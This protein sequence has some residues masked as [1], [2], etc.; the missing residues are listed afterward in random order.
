MCGRYVLRT[1]ADEVARL[2]GAVLDAS[3]APR[4]NI[5]PS[6]PVPVVRALDDGR[7]LSL[8]RWGLIPRWAKDPAIG[9]RLINA[10]S[11]TAAEK[12]SFR[13]AFARRRCLVPADAFYEWSAVPGTKRKQGWRIGLR[14]EGLFTIAGLWE[15]WTPPEGPTIESVTLL[16]T[17]ANGPIGAL[18]DRMPVIVAGPDRERWLDPAVRGETVTDLLGA[19]PDDG[20]TIVPVGPRV[21][22]PRNDDPSCFEAVA[23]QETL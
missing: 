22:D 21:N 4:W 1:P 9:N 23:R 14:P 16:T 2:L 17:G 11:E 10:R 5:A 19:W 3:F 12:P 8:L 13:D 20:V 18:H 6:Q 7:H 15:R